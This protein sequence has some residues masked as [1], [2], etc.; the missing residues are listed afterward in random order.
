MLSL[1]DPA[2]LIHSL[3][4]VGALNHSKTCRKMLNPEVSVH[5]PIP[6]ILCPDAPSKEECRCSHRTQSVLGD[7]PVAYLRPGCTFFVSK[8][9]NITITLVFG[10]CGMANQVR[11]RVKAGCDTI[12]KFS[13]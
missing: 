7:I 9:I 5:G 8:R 12:L 2:L 4:H 13:L 1:Q 11:L 6:L 3:I 10:L